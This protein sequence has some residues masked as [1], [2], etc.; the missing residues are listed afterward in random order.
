MHAGPVVAVYDLEIEGQPEFFAGGLLVHNCRVHHLGAHTMLEEQMVS[1]VPSD[2][3]DSPDRV[4]ALVWGISALK[5]LSAGNW[6][7]AYG[8]K[9]CEE[10][11][12]AYPEARGECPSCHPP[13]PGQQ[14]AA[15]GKPVKPPEPQPLT[16]WASAYGDFVRCPACQRPYDKRRAEK[17]P[18]C[19]GSTLDFL[20][21]HGQSAGAPG[22]IGM[23]GFGGMR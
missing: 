7:D 3:G 2:P 8:M 6:L 23:G 11:G 4:D 18:H 16:G 19:H 14:P 21:Q 15:T 13:E 22:S 12:K 17:C 9:R 1:W 20:R 10:C 5:G